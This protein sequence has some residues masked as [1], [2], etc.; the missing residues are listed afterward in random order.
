MVD[1]DERL[2]VTID[3][4]AGTGKSAV[5]YRLA[6]ELGISCLDT[7]AMYRC[8]ALM[9]IREG[10]DASDASVVMPAMDAH[11][12]D[13]DWTQ[14]PPMPRLDG[15]PVGDAIRST[16]IGRVVCLVA[17]VP[18]IRGAM[19]QAQ[20]RIADAHPRLVSEGRDQGSVVFPDAQAR[21][22]LTADASVRAH[23]RARQLR[24][25]GHDNVDEAEVL[26]AIEA[27]DALDRSRKIGPLTC[28]PG[29]I[30]IDTTQMGRQEVVERL[31]RDVRAIIGGA[32]PG[33]C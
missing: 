25:T 17:A 20:R 30:L 22:Y 31:A 26:E 23:R 1:A 28:A 3:G 15:M 6:A 8:V 29:A 19:V 13:F 21:F 11:P 9:T 10:I 2:I 33:S 16:E 32:V 12:I 18:E 14:H 5:S 24:A 7:G 27:R 4:P